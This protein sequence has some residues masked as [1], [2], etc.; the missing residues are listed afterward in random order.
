MDIQALLSAAIARGA[1]AD[2]VNQ[3]IAFAERQQSTEARDAFNKA[4][5][6]FRQ[7]VT[8]A[9]KNAEYDENSPWSG[10]RFANLEGVVLAVAE[11]LKAHGFTYRWIPHV[12]SQ[13][14]SVTCR[15]THIAGHSEEAQMSC[16][17]DWSEDRTEAQAVAAAVTQLE[18]HTLKAVC[19][20]VEGNNPTPAPK[21]ASVLSALSTQPSV[22]ALGRVLCALPLAERARYLADY[23]QYRRKLIPATIADEFAVRHIGLLVDDNPQGTPGWHA[24]RVGVFTASLA[25]TA[26]TRQ[27]RDAGRKRAGD[28]SEASDRLAAILAI[29]SIKGAPYREQGSSA[30]T[31][32]GHEQE[33]LARIAYEVMT[34]NLVFE[35]GLVCTPDR[36]FGYSTDGWTS[37]NTGRGRVEIK[38]LVSPARIA[39]F[40][41]SSDKR[42]WALDE[43]GLQC[44][45]ALWLTTDAWCDLIVWIPALEATG[46]NFW[47]F[48]IE[49]DEDE[50]AALGDDIG[51]FLKRKRAYEEI[52]R[53][54]KSNAR[55]TWDDVAFEVEALPEID[56]PAL[57]ADAPPPEA[58]VTP[59]PAP[60]AQPTPKPKTASTKAPK[61]ATPA[62]APAAAVALPISLF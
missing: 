13:W 3:L 14:V 31:E 33:P 25:K 56:P 46:G 17:P 37:D 26:L 9:A 24:A 5:A 41:G 4:F 23:A 22:Q 55:F 1:G 50:L 42:A 45:S 35:A 60:A 18:R 19:G 61:R 48:R 39:E 6:A 16:P 36:A 29:E 38:T 58:S 7:T 12:E 20:V 51:T 59:D 10:K 15:L 8:L 2:V 34:G 32:E 49:R 27:Q 57:P 52:F 40:M 43:F 21:R 53:Q 62:P 47:I 28:W 30:A 54:T 11:H 44:K